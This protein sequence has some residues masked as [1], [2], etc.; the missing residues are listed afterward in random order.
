MLDEGYVTIPLSFWIS[1]TFIHCLELLTQLLHSKCQAQLLIE[2]VLLH[3]LLHVNLSTTKPCCQNHELVQ[4]LNI[5]LNIFLQID[6]LL[7]LS[8]PL[9]CTE[10][11]TK[12]TWILCNYLRT[13]YASNLKQPLI[14]YLFKHSSLKHVLYRCY[15]EQDP[16]SNHHCWTDFRHNLGSPFMLLTNIATT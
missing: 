14:L 7:V 10:P 4:V 16:P 13:I 11:W 15:S 3:I 9:M 5:N 8:I 2:V 12:I 6:F 1:I